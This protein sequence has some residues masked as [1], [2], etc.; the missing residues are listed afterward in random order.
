MGYIK[1]S[2][3]YKKIPLTIQER[4]LKKSFPD[5]ITKRNKESSLF[6][7]GQLKP[8]SLSKVYTIFVQL[9]NNEIETFVITPEKLK[10]HKGEEYLPHVYST[11]KQKLCLFFG[12]REWNRSHFISDTIIP[13]ASEWL[14]YYEL[15]LITGE[16]LGGGT[17]HDVEKKNAC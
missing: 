3:R 6:W 17:V 12:S 14:Y 11:P 16:W 7:V 2:R 1:D 9:K 4:L 13:W 5:S 15:W 10:L 8:T